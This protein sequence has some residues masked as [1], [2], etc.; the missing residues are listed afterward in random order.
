[1]SDVRHQ[2][3]VI[4]DDGTVPPFPALSTFAGWKEDA[5]PLT[6]LF[7]SVP[8]DSRSV[9]KVSRGITGGQL[10]LSVPPIYPGIARANEIEDTVVLQAVID[11]EGRVQEISVK[12][13]HPLLASAAIAAVKRW[14]YQPFLLDD[15]PVRMTTQI[16][17][18]FKLK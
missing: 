5:A 10:R 4:A 7:A 3:P 14:R 8:F 13:G 18:K 6:D 16:S 15:S 11:E 2:A 12:R 1:V 17:V 9:Q